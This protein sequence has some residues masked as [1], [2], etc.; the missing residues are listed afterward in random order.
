MARAKTESIA[1]HPRAATG[2]P[3]LAVVLM[4]KNEEARLARCLDRVAGWADEIVIIDDNSSD[5]SVEIARRYTQKVYAYPSGD[6]HC[7]QWNR[8]IDHAASEWILH[9]DADEWVTPK[10]KQ[11]IDRA[12]ANAQDRRAFELIRLN[13]FL[14]QPMRFGGWRQ[15]HLILFRR[16][17]T[18][19][20][21][22]GIHTRNRLQF[23]GSVG[24]INEEIEHYPFPSIHTFIE[25]Q[26][27]Y[28]S[29]EAAASL[30]DHG[31]A[32]F[33]RVVFQTTVRPLKLFWKGFIRQQ[34]YKD[35]WRGWVLAWLSAFTHF[36]H[37]AKCWEAAQNRSGAGGLDAAT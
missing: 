10:L 6:D 35:G 17:G 2:R 26:N 21:G 29:V 20:V 9:I 4:V 13:F 37:W 27:L 23:S 24:F 33:K 7:L 32:D 12:L 30:R 1:Q 5:R 8:G 25:R 28:T 36:I 18:R 11:A 19:C 15:R 22:S 31:P 14:G 16:Q 3:T 34:G